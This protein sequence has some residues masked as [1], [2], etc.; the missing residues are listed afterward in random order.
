MSNNQAAGHGDE[1]SDEPQTHQT[2]DWLEWLREQV[3]YDDQDDGDIAG[4]PPLKP[5]CSMTK[6]VD[7]VFVAQGGEV[8]FEVLIEEMPPESEG[9]GGSS[10]NHSQDHDHDHDDEQS[11]AEPSRR[12]VRI[13]R[14]M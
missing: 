14:G 10:Q 12:V 11:A 1:A 6:P 2:Y 9:Q 3:I 4:K 13:G 8:E 7:D 5:A